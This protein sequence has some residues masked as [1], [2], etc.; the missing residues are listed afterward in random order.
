MCVE[1]NSTFSTR[2]LFQMHGLMKRSEINLLRVH[3][4]HLRG[5][6]NDFRRC[7]P[8]VCTF[9]SCSS[10]LHIRRVHGKISMRTILGEVHPVGA[11][12]KTSISDTERCT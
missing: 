10:L 4:T 7:A 9:L 11:Q 2:L 8:G 3:P 1:Y 6:V 12:N 5:R